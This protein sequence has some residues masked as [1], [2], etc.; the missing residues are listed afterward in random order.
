MVTADAPTFTQTQTRWRGSIKLNKR[1]ED[2]CHRC[3][4]SRR[5]PRRPPQSYRQPRTAIGLRRWRLP[6]T[7]EL[8]SG[9]RLAAHRRP[10]AWPRRTANSIEFIHS[11]WALVQVSRRSRPFFSIAP[12]PMT[13]LAGAAR[14]D[15]TKLEAKTSAFNALDGY[16]RRTSTLRPGFATGGNKR[17][18]R[19]RA[20]RLQPA[21]YATRSSTSAPSERPFRADVT[22]IFLI[23]RYELRKPSARCL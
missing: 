10:E 8:Y 15:I 6:L 23:P 14:R 11:S 2:H 13:L 16:E 7:P 3:G 9:R 20:D 1:L 21:I 17:P 12:A 18:G 22:D 4:S 5:L 19:H